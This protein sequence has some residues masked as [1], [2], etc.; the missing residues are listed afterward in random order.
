MAAS[1]DA[2]SRGVGGG[3]RWPDEGPRIREPPAVTGFADP[4]PPFGPTPDTGFPPLPAGEGMDRVFPLEANCHVG[5]ARYPLRPRPRGPRRRVRL[6]RLDQP[7]PALSRPA[8][9]GTR[10]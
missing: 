6:A 7:G 10:G 5:A 3:G 1:R 4:H 9:R 8:L 2:F